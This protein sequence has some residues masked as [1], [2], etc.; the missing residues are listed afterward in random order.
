MIIIKLYLEVT[1]YNRIR[2]GVKSL[3]LDESQEFSD[4][5]ITDSQCLT[6]EILKF[7]ENSLL[8]WWSI[9]KDPKRRG[10]RSVYPSHRPLR[11]RNAI[12]RWI[13][14]V[15]NMLRSAQSDRSMEEICNAD[16]TLKK[17]LPPNT[18][19]SGTTEFSTTK[20]Y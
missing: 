3:S 17:S 11:L 2:Y 15:R 14:Y 9:Y 1:I 8:E 18:L 4:A 7:K 20:A 10:S 16:Q 12:R 19:C 6:R 13:C 5:S